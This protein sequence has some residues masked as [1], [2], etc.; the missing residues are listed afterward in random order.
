M[1]NCFPFFHVSLKIS[2]MRSDHLNKHLKTHSAQSTKKTKDEKGN[3]QNN[4]QQPTGLSQVKLE[5]V[6]QE[7]NENLS[8]ASRLNEERLMYNGVSNLDH[9][10]TNIQHN[11]STTSNSELFLSHAHSFAPMLDSAGLSAGNM[12]FTMPYY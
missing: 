2:F 7:K 4:G 9:Y 1:L 10:Q 5:K 11:V 12:G 8:P 6:K 3:K